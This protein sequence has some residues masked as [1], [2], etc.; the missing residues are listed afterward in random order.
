MH[1]L[2]AIWR[3]DLRFNY[4]DTFH[5]AGET[6]YRREVKRVCERHERVFCLN[7]LPTLWPHAKPALSSLVP[8]DGFPAYFSRH[9]V[10]QVRNK[11]DSGYKPACLVQTQSRLSLWDKPSFKLWLRCFRLDVLI[12]TDCRFESPNLWNPP[13]RTA[14]RLSASHCSTPA[15][16]LWPPSQVRGLQ[17]RA[18]VL[19]SVILMYCKK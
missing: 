14:S 13:I 5:S 1:T 2:A 4:S 9:E 6:E 10:C 19:S 7:H 15:A 16:W 17:G 11:Y 18:T 3:F 12:E 8:T